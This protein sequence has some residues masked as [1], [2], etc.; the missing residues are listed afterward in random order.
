MSIQQTIEEKLT[1]AFEPTF[2]D[3]F[4]ESHQHRGPATESHFKVILVSEAFV[5]KSRIARHRAVN[6]VLSYEL[7]HHIH[8]LSL[9]LYTPEQWDNQVKIPASPPCVKK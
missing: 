1:Q 5:E 2:L 3:V 9:N 8:A 7:E 4:N 6:Q